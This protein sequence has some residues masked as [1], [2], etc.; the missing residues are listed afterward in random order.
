M[1][2]VRFEH[3]SKRFPNGDLAVNDLTLKILDGEFIVV[4]GPSGCGKST[5]LRLLAGLEYPDEG[6]IWIGDRLVNDVPT[7]NRDV[8]MVFQDYA[9]YPHLSA[10]DNMGF[11]LRMQGTPVP[12]INWRVSRAAD[13]LEIVPILDRMPRELSGG[14]QQRVA[15][16]RAIVKE[17]SIFLL[18]EPLSSVDAKLRERMRMELLQL[19]RKL[20]RTFIYVTHDQREAMT[21]GD[22]VAVMKDGVLQQVAPPSEIYDHPANVFVAGFFGSPAMNFIPVTIR[23]RKVTGSAIELELPQPCRLERGVLGIR[24]EALSLQVEPDEP[25]IDLKVDLAESIGQHQLV[26]GEAG[27][28]GLVARL[29]AGLKV[30]RGDRMRLRVDPRR[31][32]VFDMDGGQAVI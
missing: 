32:H 21:L 11:G 6:E 10:F 29:D 18:D 7:R 31:I 8:S 4:V 19:H 13:V 22:R 25:T 1:A 14:E 15:L 12:D 3:I 16:G 17:A 9:L 28:D 2:P 20:H 5:T 26:Y 30:H 23:G 24:P 27:D